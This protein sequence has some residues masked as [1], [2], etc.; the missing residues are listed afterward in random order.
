MWGSSSCNLKERDKVS[1]CGS[2]TVSVVVSRKH[3]LNKKASNDFKK[4]TWLAHLRWWF[5]A[6]DEMSLACI[7]AVWSEPEL[8]V[9]KQIADL[10]GRPLSPR[11]LHPARRSPLLHWPATRFTTYCALNVRKAQCQGE[12]W[13][14]PLSQDGA[15]RFTVVCL[16]QDKVIIF[17]I[18]ATDFT[19]IWLSMA[20]K[21]CST[22]RLHKIILAPAYAS[23]LHVS[24]PIPLLPPVTRA[25]LPR[26]SAW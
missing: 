10:Q 7:Y 6:A 9:G 25:T 23:A 12:P 24:S 19:L 26:R 13:I 18:R 2:V 8:Q 20:S 4:K 17:I 3:G 16:S 21:P 15:C 1:L 5:L 14:F 22:W 11:Y